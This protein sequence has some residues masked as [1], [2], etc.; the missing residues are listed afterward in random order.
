MM[1]L[2]GPLAKFGICPPVKKAKTSR[3]ERRDGS[4][5]E[6]FAILR[7]RQSSS[8]WERP[9][10]LQMKFLR[11]LSGT[12]DEPK[13][14]SES[15]DRRDGGKA[16]AVLLLIALLVS[17][18]G[19]RRGAKQEPE[20]KITFTQVPQR[21]SGDRN[22]QD[23]MEGKI[24]GARPGQQLVVYSKSGG[25]WWLQPLI[26]SPFTEI[27]PGG[28]WRIETHLGT[29]YAVLLVDPSYSP[30]GTLS[31]LP[32]KGLGITAVAITPGQEKSSS[33]FVDFSGYTWRVRWKPSNRGGSVNPYHPEN[34]Y[35][36]PSG[37][38]HLRIVQRGQQWTCSEVNLTRSL[39]YGTYSFT[40]ED[41]SRLEPAAVF[42]I[43]TWDYSTDRDNHREFD[44]NVGRWGAP[45]NKNAEFVLQPGF[46][47]ANISRFVVPADKLKYTIVWEPG[48]LN[49]TASRASGTGRPAVVASH[50]FTSEV[51]TPGSE[52]LRM[53]LF[54]YSDGN[55]KSQRIEHP[56]EVVVD[57][58][59][60]LP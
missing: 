37:A 33:F 21:D 23:V 59:E 29:E 20:V 14:L 16:Y 22:V 6:A 42:G 10:I 60:F 57:R 54:I 48:R 27:L 15:E 49:M 35:T 52:S 34:V 30:A 2:L 58:F 32:K 51:P 43:F 13:K 3:L 9:A 18:A 12:Q 56:A 11:T 39:G 8:R 7:A 24:S 47:P 31:Q 53:S 26:T 4:G 45:D 17:L 50:T 5:P 41:T 38:L 25:L 1:W 44:L 40:V 28:V 55:G 19:C 36:D 46:V